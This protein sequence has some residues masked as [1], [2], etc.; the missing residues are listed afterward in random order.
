M[1]QV[2]TD[3]CTRELEDKLG[4]PPSDAEL[5]DHS[6]LSMKRLQ[7]IRQGRSVAESQ[8]ARTTKQNT[9]SYESA[10]RPVEKDSADSPWVE[11]V[12]T[13]LDSRDQF[14]MERLLG[15]RGRTPISITGVAR[16]LSITPSAV[17]R[18]AA[19]IQEQLNRNDRFGL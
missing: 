17:S 19:K 7:Y 16:L 12:Y 3:A 4:R 2:A 15:M 1:D 9:Q 14:I 10:V 6:G 8:L 13:G 18:R 11:F 5:A